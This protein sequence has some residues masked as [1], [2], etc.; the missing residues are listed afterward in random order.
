MRHHPRPDRLVIARQIELGDGPAI[1]A[2][3]PQHLVGLGDCYTHD[4][5]ILFPFGLRFDLVSHLR[6][7]ARWSRRIHVVTRACAPSRSP[8]RA[9]AE[10]TPALRMDTW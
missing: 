1:A 8:R 2:V 4:E 5:A 10:T 3:G 7:D 6:W 9:I